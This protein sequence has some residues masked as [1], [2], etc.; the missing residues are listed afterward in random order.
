M[1]LMSTHNIYFASEIRIVIFQTH[2]IIWRYGPHGLAMDN[3]EPI[4]LD[5]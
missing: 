1:V 5:K 4:G 3:R 2:T